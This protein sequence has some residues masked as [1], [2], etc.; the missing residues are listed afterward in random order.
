MKILM[1]NDN[2]PETVVG[3]GERY[4]A[5]VTAALT[6]AGHRVYW[7]VLS[8]PEIPAPES[9]RKHVFRVAPARKAIAIL[10]HAAYY[11]EAHR[12]LSDCIARVRPDVVHLHNN[13]RYPVAILAALRGSRV[14]QTV[15]DYC[16]VYPTAYCTRQPSCAGRSVFAALGHGCVTWKLLATEA[17]LM[18]GRRFLD[19]RVVD[20][21]IAPSRHLATLLDRMGYAGVQ[22]LPNFRLPNFRLLPEAGPTPP[23]DSQVVLYVGSLVA[24]KGIDVLLAAFA[25]LVR[26]M[27]QASLWLAGDGPD[28]DAFKAS[29]ARRGL[30]RVRFLGRLE[31]SGLAEVYREAR[32]VAI[33]SLWL[34]NAPLVAIE[35]TAYGRAVVASRVGGLPELVEDGETGYLFDRADVAGL[36]AKLKLL[37]ADRA[38]AERL[39]AAGNERFAKLRQPARHVDRL[40]AIYGNASQRD[41]TKS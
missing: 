5:D 2:D 15:H 14:V 25:E 36:A 6:A 11:R 39:G 27:P 9:P 3:G 22:Y 26:D 37:L 12:A 40:L 10:R 23:P 34:E 20:R 30:C 1:V 31:P 28:S 35:A 24:H 8:D 32:V 38:L 7:F 18:Y 19:R 16:A 33:P 41:S 29:V 17:G 13:Y 4:I 21:F